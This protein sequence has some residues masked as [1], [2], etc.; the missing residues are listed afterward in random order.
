MLA[1]TVRLWNTGEEMHSTG[2]YAGMSPFDF[3]ATF[4]T[5]TDRLGI[6]MHLDAITKSCSM[7]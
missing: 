7:L 5:M 1:N 6:S 2:L 4:L 3:V